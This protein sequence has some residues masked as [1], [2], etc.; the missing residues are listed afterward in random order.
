ML[1]VVIEC[2][3][4][5]MLEMCIGF[6]FDVGVMYFLLGMLVEFE[7]Y[8][9]L[10][11]VMLLGVDVLIVKFVDLCVL[12]VW[13]DMFEMCIESVKWDGDVLLLLCKVFELLCN[14][15]LYVVFDS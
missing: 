13:F 3:K 14:V 11:G 15:V 1:C 12:F 4:I 7:L 2:S 9:G 10:I 8:V 6:V 5:V